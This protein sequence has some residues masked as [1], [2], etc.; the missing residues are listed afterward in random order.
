MSKAWWLYL[1]L[2]E[3]GMTYA[4]T[5]ADVEVRFQKHLAGKGARFTRINKPID[6]LAA[7]PF[8]DRASACKAEY[9]LKQRSQKEKLE[10]AQEWEWPSVPARK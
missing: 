9:A 10:W 4:G 5:A 7:Q 1:L 2:C 8:P 3:G 6:I